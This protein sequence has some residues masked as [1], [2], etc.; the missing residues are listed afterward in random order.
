MRKT[1]FI[2][3]AALSTAATASGLSESGKQKI[4][5]CND[6]IKAFSASAS[7]REAMLSPEVALKQ[8]EFVKH[9]PEA[10]KKEIVNF[11][12]FDPAGVGI[13]P[14][15]V[16]SLGEVYDWCMRDWKPLYQPLK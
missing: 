5:Y 14:Q 15:N 2:L 1:A 6:S 12:Y 11:V 16:T 7:A 9:V 4:N 3:L 10:D 13:S 8:L